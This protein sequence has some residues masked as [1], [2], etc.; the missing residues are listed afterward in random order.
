MS[1]KKKVRARYAHLV[2]LLAAPAVGK[3]TEAM[4][5]ELRA[6]AAVLFGVKPSLVPVK[7][8]K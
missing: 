6:L 7:I 5:R 8:R 1:S 2:E 4:K 3:P